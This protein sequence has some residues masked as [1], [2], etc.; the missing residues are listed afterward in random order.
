MEGDASGSEA[1]SGEILR[2]PSLIVRFAQGK[3]FV[4]QQDPFGSSWPDG[5][6]VIALEYRCDTGRITGLFFRAYSRR[7]ILVDEGVK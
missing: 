1:P 2:R 4:K 5:N 6:N 7:S 3:G